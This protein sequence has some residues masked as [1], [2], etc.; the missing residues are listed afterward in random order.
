MSEISLTID[1]KTGL[2]AIL[3]LLLLNSVLAMAETALLSARK[4]RLQN[5]SNQGEPHT[6]SFL[7]LDKKQTDLPL[8]YFHR[9]YVSPPPPLNWAFLVWNS[10]T[11]L[12][13]DRINHR[14][15]R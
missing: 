6:G 3:I 10:E 4:A 11:V 13:D 5:L 9:W 2:A 14:V 15:P 8:S 1:F 12:T 7:K